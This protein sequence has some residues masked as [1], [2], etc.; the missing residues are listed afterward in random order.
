VIARMTGELFRELSADLANVRAK[1]SASE[2]EL[3]LIGG[4][5]SPSRQT[6][7]ACGHPLALRR[8]GISG[9]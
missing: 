6:S 1:V 8:D 7:K 9:A 4:R 2:R 5:G 3:L